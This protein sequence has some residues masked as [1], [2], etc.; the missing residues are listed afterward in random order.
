MFD[1]AQHCSKWFIWIQLLAFGDT[2]AA[3]FVAGRLQ[4][5]PG[6]VDPSGE[7]SAEPLILGLEAAWGR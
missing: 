1:N 2:E 6:E 7:K 4:V 5:H 3:L